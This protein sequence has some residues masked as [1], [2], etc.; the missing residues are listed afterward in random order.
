MNIRNMIVM[1][2][3]YI[4]TII[5]DYG[6]AYRIAED[7]MAAANAYYDTTVSRYEIGYIALLLE[8][9]LEKQMGITDRILL[10]CMK[11]KVSALYLV[12]N[13]KNI[14]CDEVQTIET[15]SRYE[16]QKKDIDAY[17]AVFTTISGVKDPRI[18][19][20]SEYQINGSPEYIRRIYKTAKN[21]H[22]L[23]QWFPE[24]KCI[25]H[26]TARAIE[27]KIARYLQREQC[28]TAFNTSSA[29]LVWTKCEDRDQA[30]I[31]IPFQ[32]FSFRG[33]ETKLVIF[34]KQSTEDLKEFIPF[35][36]L[37]YRL[38]YDETLVQKILKM[39]KQ[40][41]LLEL[42]AQ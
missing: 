6:C 11:G 25:M 7:A 30:K 21:R 39:Q 18:Y 8:M 27:E 23:N 33:H 20:I 36:N 40:E 13:L 14:M 12:E 32:P 34:Q 15:C 16:L 5:R 42:F 38:L 19:E 35:N 28:R 22:I 41:E 4:D 1:D 17:T 3:P 2:D 37:I 26:D 24:R 31:C 29:L 10:V 9:Q